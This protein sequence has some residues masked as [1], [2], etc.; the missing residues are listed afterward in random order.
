MILNCILLND[1]NIEWLNKE[2]N[3]F[4]LS[5]DGRKEVND[6][7]RKSV[8]GKS[9]FDI[10]LKNALKVKNARNGKQYYVRGTYTAKNL[11]F[12]NDVL[13]LND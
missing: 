13:L 11:D 3:N 2:M 8:N 10:V 9:V 12:T 1:E 7:V 5:I 4:V 6:N